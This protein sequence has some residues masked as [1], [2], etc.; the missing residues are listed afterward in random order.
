M[1]MESRRVHGMFDPTT[2]YGES[3]FDH[4]VYVILG[5]GCMQ[6]GVAAEAVARYSSIR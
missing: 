4:N 2:P 5:D 3:V 6:E 1:A